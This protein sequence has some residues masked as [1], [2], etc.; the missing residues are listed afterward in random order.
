MNVFDYSQLFHLMERLG[1][2]EK[3]WVGHQYNSYGHVVSTTGALSTI[4]NNV[5]F[6]LRE[7]RRDLYQYTCISYKNRTFFNEN[8]DNVYYFLCSYYYSGMLLKHHR[9]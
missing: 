2:R 7:S 9:H 8:C 5:K 4:L 6:F 3:F 1:E